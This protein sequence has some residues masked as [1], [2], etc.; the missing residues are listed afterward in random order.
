[1]SKSLNLDNVMKP[2]MEIV[3]YIRTHALNHRQFKKLIN[4]LDQALISDLPLHCS[5][6]WLSKSQ[7]LSQFFQLLDVVKL[8]MEEKNKIYPELSDLG[9]ILDWAFLVEILYHLDRLNLN[10]HGKLKMLPDLSVKRVS[11]CQQT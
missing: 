7:V 4:E 3:K 9:W 5:V 11:V 2:I 1:M 6:R 8:F 10:L